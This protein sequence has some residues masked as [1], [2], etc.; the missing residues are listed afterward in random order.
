MA[1]I[2]REGAVGAAA[3][4]ERGAHRSAIAGAP[5]LDRS[6]CRVFSLQERGDLH[7]TSNSNTLLNFSDVH[8][9]G[10]GGFGDVY[11]CDLII[12][13][14]KRSYAVK[15]MHKSISPGPFRVLEGSGGFDLLQSSKRGASLCSFD[16][17]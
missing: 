12:L 4:V 16:G 11:G 5:V 2:R 15:K 13:Q 10:F 3:A 14:R 9:L 17:S 6:Q 7:F 8:L 1:T